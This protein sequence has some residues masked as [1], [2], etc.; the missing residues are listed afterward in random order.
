MS[1]KLRGFLGVVVIAMAAAWLVSCGGTSHPAGVLLA[2]SQGATLI[3]S[4]GVNLTT[5]V[6][7]QINTA[8]KVPSSTA[9]SATVIDSAGATLYVANAALS[10]PTTTAGSISVYTVNSNATLTAAGSGAT[11]GINPVALTLDPSGKFLLVVN[12]L[13]NN[14]SVFSVSSGG[15]LSEVSGSPFATGVPPTTVN[16]ALP[17]PSAVTVTPSNYVYVANQGQD[18]VSAFS[19][20]P[21]SGFLTPLAGLP[22]AV[23]L[24][25]SGVANTITSSGT[26]VLFV[27]NQGDNNVSSFEI[28]SDG[29]LT[30][31]PKSPFASGLGPGAM[32]IEP[33][34]NFLYVAD[35][36]SNQVT[37]FRINPG[38]GALTALIAV[39][40]GSSPV[41][42][43]IHPNGLF[44]YTAN[45]SSDNISGFSL[46][47]LSG[48]LA[49]IATSTSSSRPAG[50]AIK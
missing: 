39:S 42:L 34:K 47:P 44:L 50:L 43:V 16:T 10:S 17:V 2:T 26:R 33:T 4:Y 27:A 25:P 48:A 30:A 9:P 15:S 36:N 6:L 45:I 19:L 28:N 49:P 23:G 22:T 29:T 24:A 31:S 12:Q 32:A 41:A 5:G 3:E 20:D 37:P 35:M 21:S 14:V 38:D 1:I 18:T 46:N 7:S 11:T 8:G 40:T 13:S